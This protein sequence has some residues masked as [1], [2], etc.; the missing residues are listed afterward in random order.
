MFCIT[1]LNEVALSVLKT[2]RKNCHPLFILA[3]IKRIFTRKELIFN[4]QYYK[5]FSLNITII[6]QKSIPFNQTDVYP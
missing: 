4:L 2:F 6:N 5:I 3:I 1:L